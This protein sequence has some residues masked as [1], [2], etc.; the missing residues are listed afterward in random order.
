MKWLQALYKLEDGGIP[1]S[2]ENKGVS[3]GMH[4]EILRQV[5]RTK[6]LNYGGIQQKSGGI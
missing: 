4:Q 5:S 1:D 6:N 3:Q 2:D